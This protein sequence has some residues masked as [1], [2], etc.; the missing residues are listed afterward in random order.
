MTKTKEAPITVEQ[1]R[2]AALEY[3]IELIKMDFPALDKE[4][5]RKL[6]ARHQELQK[7]MFET[8]KLS[9]KAI[10]FLFEG[11]E[12]VEV[13]HD[14]FVPTKGKA[15]QRAL[16]DMRVLRHSNLYFICRCVESLNSRKSVQE[17]AAEFKLKEDLVKFVL[18]SYQVL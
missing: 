12:K 10:D 6:Y 11:F 16:E 18:K 4:A 3:R 2:E 1:F 7:C 17:I 8:P 15:M 9:P 14:E 5:I 13:K